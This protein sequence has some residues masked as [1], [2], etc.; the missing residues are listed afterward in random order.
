[1]LNAYVMTESHNENAVGVSDSNSEDIYRARIKDIYSEAFESWYHTSSKI[2]KTYSSVCNL[3]VDNCSIFYMWYRANEKL[4]NLFGIEPHAGNIPIMVIVQT[5]L[6]YF[7]V[8]LQMAAVMLIAN[9]EYLIASHNGKLSRGRIGGTLA[10]MLAC[11]ACVPI[12]MWS[13]TAGVYRFLS[14]VTSVVAYSCSD[15]LRSEFISSLSN[16]TY[17]AYD[18]TYKVTIGIIG[19][20]G[21]PTVHPSIISPYGNST[22]GSRE[23]ST[24]T[25]TTSMLQQCIALIMSATVASVAALLVFWYELSRAVIWRPI[26]QSTMCMVDLCSRQRSTSGSESVQA[27]SPESLTSVHAKEID[28]EP[29]YD[30]MELSQKLESIQMCSNIGRLLVSIAQER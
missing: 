18:S 20:E 1:M 13:V 21:K 10:H 23:R 29:T 22:H 19:V 12:V 5:V 2:G 30:E 9:V 25:S 4:L 16:T 24:A 3:A 14:A 8:P 26:Y 27:P 11:L 28:S 17:D 7:F 15:V 6:L